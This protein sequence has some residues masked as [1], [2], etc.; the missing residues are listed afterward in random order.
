MSKSGLNPDLFGGWPWL[1]VD[2]KIHQNCL[3]SSFQHSGSRPAPAEDS[4]ACV[5]LCDE[6]EKSAVLTST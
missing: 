1:Q 6:V 4:S 2:S 5:S 3:E